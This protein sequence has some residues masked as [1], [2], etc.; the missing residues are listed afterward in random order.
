MRNDLHPRELRALGA[1]VRKLRARR[2]FSQEG[3]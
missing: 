1:A 2:G 3:G